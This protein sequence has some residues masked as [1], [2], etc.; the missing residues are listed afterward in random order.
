LQQDPIVRE[1]AAE[2]RVPP[3]FMLVSV[4]VVGGTRHSL[5]LGER[6]AQRERFDPH[7]GRAPRNVRS[8][9]QWRLW[10]VPETR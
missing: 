2:A 9:K 4:E 5:R 6:H 7:Q 3:G 10:G 8:L 1:V